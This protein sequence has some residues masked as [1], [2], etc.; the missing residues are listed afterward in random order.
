MRARTQGRHDD[1]DDDDDDDDNVA[2]GRAFPLQ[3]K[4]SAIYLTAGDEQDCNSRP[5][6]HKPTM[7]IYF[8]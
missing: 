8:A 3:Y 1:D 7:P 6:R 4:L 2:R 5:E